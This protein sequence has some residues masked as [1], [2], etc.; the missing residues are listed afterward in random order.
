M[1]ERPAVAITAIVAA[2]I[3]VVSFL[4]AVTFLAYTGRGTEALTG[5][6]M[7]GLVAALAS[8][9]QKIKNVEKHV[10]PSTDGGS[11]DGR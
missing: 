4:A 10:S 9:Y 5:A 7:I 1:L 8:V 6:G 2:V 11:G 3:V